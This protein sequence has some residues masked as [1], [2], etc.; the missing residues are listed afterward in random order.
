[1]NRGAREAAGSVLLF[2]HADVVL[3]PKAGTLIRE[4]LADNEVA[5]GWFR[6]RT[7]V[8][9]GSGCLYRVLVSMANW[10]S[11]FGRYPYGDQ[12]IFLRRRVFEKMCGFAEIP[13]M[14]DI[15]FSRRLRREGRLA[16]IGA[17]VEVSGRRWE[18]SLFKNA[19][20]LKLLPLLYRLGVSPETLTR[21]YGE[22]R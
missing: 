18:R 10:R 6:I 4:V 19:V 20:K 17:C 7:T 15:E 8:P 2:L 13:L 1:M 16:R 12:A 9:P 5:G 22:V 21:F 3:P 11:R 14:E